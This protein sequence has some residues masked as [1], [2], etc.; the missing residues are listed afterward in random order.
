M[1]SLKDIFCVVAVILL[2]GVGF[3]VVLNAIKGLIEY[4][5]FKKRYPEPILGK[6]SSLWTM[7][8]VLHKLKLIS[9]DSYSKSIKL[10]TN[11]FKI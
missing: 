1:V 3:S 4:F 11:K 9:Y 10:I 8:V 6:F 7:M 5:S 2:I